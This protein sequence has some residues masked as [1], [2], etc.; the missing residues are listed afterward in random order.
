MFFSTVLA[1]LAVSS[2]AQ[3]APMRHPKR[4][5]AND[6]T[7]LKFANVLEQLETEFYTQALAKF[8]EADFITAGFSSAAVATEQFTNILFDEST[9]TSILA[10]TLSSF[11]EQAV[12]GCKFDFSSVLT[13]VATMAGVARLV[14]NLGVSAYL[15]GA[16]LIDDKQLLIA[17]ATILTTEARHQTMLNVLNSGVAIPQ[18]F[19]IALAP[20][21]VLSIASPFISGCDLGIPANTALKATNTGAIGP[22]STIT[23]DS[24]AIASQNRSALFCQMMTG[25]VPFAASF[26]IDNCIVPAGLEGPVY[27]FLTNTSQPLLNSQQNQFANS[28]IAGPMGMFIDTKKETISALFKSGAVAANV[29]VTST[30]A[31]T[32]TISSAEASAVIAAAAAPSAVTTP[33]AAVASIG[34]SESGNSPAKV[35]G[36]SKAS[37]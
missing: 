22:G 19:D 20:S 18:A 23:L 9:H 2:L 12:T 24:P 15:G 14:E 33:Q 26:P 11:G 35:I 32:Q 17:A 31:S 37:R 3:A 25:G 13:D 4:A 30:S 28:I 21:Q 16:A 7:V 6:I 36:W 27:I 29:P 8:K 1:V 34:G 5:S 10:S